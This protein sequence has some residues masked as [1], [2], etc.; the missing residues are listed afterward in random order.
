MSCYAECKLRKIHYTNTDPWMCDYEKTCNK[1]FSTKTKITIKNNT[2]LI[3]T[4]SITSLCIKQKT[5]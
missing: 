3:K 4:P 1:K 2:V 5:E